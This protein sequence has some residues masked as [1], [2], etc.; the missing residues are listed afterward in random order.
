MW[1][2][3]FYAYYRGYCTPTSKGTQDGVLTLLDADS[4][5]NTVP[6]GTKLDFI[7]LRRITEGL[8]Q[9]I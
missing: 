5:S 3:V 7:H 2:G 6:D 1:F 4:H 8:S 9:A